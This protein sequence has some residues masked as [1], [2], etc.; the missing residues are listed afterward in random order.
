MSLT[1]IAWLLTYFYLMLR[2]LVNPVF[3]SC[4]Y[5]LTFYAA[6]QF[7]WWGAAITSLPIRWNLVTGLFLAVFAF[8][9]PS[10]KRRLGPVDRFFLL[11]LGLYIA[12]AFMVNSTLAANPPRSAM[13]F[14]TLWKG[15]ILALVLR[16][17]VSDFKG[18]NTVLF[19]ILILSAY[20]AYEV[21]FNGAGRMTQGR[22]E[23]LRFPGAFAS[24]GTAI[25]MS[26]SLPFVAYFF[27]INPIPYSR[28][29][30]FL[31]A[32]FILNVVLL[33]NSRGTYLG[34]AA[35]GLMM[36]FFARGAAR[37]YSIFI[38]LA[39]IAA[40]LFLARDAQIWERLFSITANSEEREA[41]A[42]SRI[43][44]TLAALRM[45]QDY[46]WGSGG[47]AAFYSERGFSYIIPLGQKTPRAAHNGYTNIMAGWGIQGFS[48]LIMAVGTSLFA[49][50]GSLRRLDPIR[51]TKIAFLGACIIAAI[52]G[53]LVST[54]FGD[55]LDG[56]WFLWL[57][58]LALSLS[59]IINNNDHDELENSLCLTGRG[60]L[61]DEV[62]ALDFEHGEV[63]SD[64]MER[65]VTL[66]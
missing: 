14:D 25:L 57:T 63:V 62:E 30:A 58:T 64:A 61:H 55:Y 52:F 9:G 50:V 33:C 27:I 45:V 3:I 47:G 54:C 32:P 39:G 26:M 53:Q 60:A 4:A 59:S 37:K 36:I 11:C 2:G 28:L 49:L 19:T 38:A 29:F 22:L 17:V 34:T 46:P 24:N 8:L 7:W 23:G 51:H 35:G 20:I 56:E 13:E 44:F 6:P 12:N 41:S 16:F 43:N 1:A 42:Q 31:A 40:F 10:E 5:L 65:E 15:G 48:L 18:L 21:Y 66:Q